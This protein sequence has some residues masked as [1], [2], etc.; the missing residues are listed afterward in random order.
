MRRLARY[1]DAPTTS[2]I[3]SPPGYRLEEETTWYSEHVSVFLAVF[4]FDRRLIRCIPQLS[5]VS[6]YPSL[7]LTSLRSLNGGFD[8]PELPS[9]GCSRAPVVFT[10]GSRS[11]NGENV[12]RPNSYRSILLLPSLLGGSGGKKKVIK[13]ISCSSCLCHA[14]ICRLLIIGVRLEEQAGKKW[15]LQSCQRSTLY[16]EK[17]K[18]LYLKKMVVVL[19][20]LIVRDT[21]AV[22]ERELTHVP[23]FLSEFPR[24][25]QK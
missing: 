17:Q 7:F 9:G 21:C 11:A 10:W 13:V 14:E 2:V 19:L 24:N 12:G 8:I 18:M 23:G 4:S 15:Q 22:W 20:F 1:S 25:K 3:L 16:T 6:F 5:F